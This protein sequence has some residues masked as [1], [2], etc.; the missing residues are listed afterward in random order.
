MKCKFCNTENAEGA[1]FCCNCGKRIDN[2]II[3]ASCGTAFIGRFCPNCGK[4]S[5]ANAQPAPVH[6]TQPAPYSQPAPYTQPAPA[7][8]AQPA[9]APAPAAVQEEPLTGWKKWVHLSGT[10]IGLLGVIVS[11]IA[12]FLV[13]MTPFMNA[14]GESVDAALLSDTIG[15]VI[16]IKW[17]FD[18]EGLKEIIER[19]SASDGQN[20]MS[21]ILRYA[22]PAIFGAFIFIGIVIAIIVMAI[23]AIVRYIKVLCGKQTKG[24][25]KITISIFL[26]YLMGTTW[27]RS[28]FAFNVT[29][30]SFGETASYGYML[31]SNT[32]A[33]IIASGVCV[34]LLAAT[35]IA[36]QGKSLI[37]VTNILK[38]IFGI[39]AIVAAFL[40]WSYSTGA[41][42]G[43]TMSRE[44]SSQTVLYGFSQLMREFENINFETIS[45]VDEDLAGNIIRVVSFALLGQ[46]FLFVLVPLIFSTVSKN[47]ANITDKKSHSPLGIS[48]A[49]LIFS[50]IFFAIIYAA[51]N[52]LFAFK[53]Y[54][55]ELYADSVSK[56]MTPAIIVVATSVVTL[57]L[58]I[59]DKIVAGK[60]NN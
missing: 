39:L 2:K 9:P 32:V 18:L 13:G 8:Y 17:F 28:L 60:A 15:D 47:Y 1:T 46:I 54:D 27:I 37:K 45:K 30:D 38:V 4:Q 12:V 49:L 42:I 43:Y 29:S 35:R 11:I 33:C 24:V 50:L 52:N 16:G 41:V 3:C 48:I 23:I 5:E 31:S 10:I 59:A 56:A 36:V 58:A 20:A 26:T 40:L 19:A 21:L 7:P 44:G 22:L 25:E 55:N 34:A 51:T 57:I 53:G 6:Y 14:L